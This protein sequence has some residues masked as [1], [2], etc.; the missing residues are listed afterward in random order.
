[1]KLST[2]KP[3]N[4]DELVKRYSVEWGPTV[5]TYGDTVYCGY[6]LSDDVVVH[7]SVHIEQQATIGVETWWRR[8]YDDPQF[9][10]EQELEAYRAQYKF[11]KRTIKD[12][13]K[14]NQRLLLLASYLSGD[15]YENIVTKAEAMKAIRG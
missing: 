9:R 12:R 8:Y 7:E 11:I 1:M 5:V 15:M 4:W 2:Q 3:P 10:Y 13:N 6:K 14:M